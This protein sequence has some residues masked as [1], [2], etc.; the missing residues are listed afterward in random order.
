M[1]REEALQWAYLF[2]S[3]AQGKKILIADYD[4]DYNEIFRE[5]ESADEWIE[6]AFEQRDDPKNFKVAE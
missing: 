2:L 5:G 1:D 3:Y 6:K 4:D